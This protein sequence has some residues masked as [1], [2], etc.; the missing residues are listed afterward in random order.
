[1]NQ[2]NK[3]DDHLGDMAARDRS[4]LEDLTRQLQIV[5]QNADIHVGNAS[6]AIYAANAIKNAYHRYCSLVKILPSIS[7]PGLEKIEYIIDCMKKQQMW[8]HNYKSRKDSIMTLVYN[9]VTQQDAIN[10]FNLAVNMKRDSASMNSI[11]ALTMIFLP[12]SFTA[13]SRHILCYCNSL[14]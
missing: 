10:N 7:Q 9:L 6:V 8:F 2:F 11:A 14:N 3:V 5:S 13:V 1:L 12:G 4:K